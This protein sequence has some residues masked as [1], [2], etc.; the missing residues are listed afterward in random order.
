MARVYYGQEKMMLC[1]DD[2][3]IGAVKGRRPAFKAAKQADLTWRPF[4][5]SD[6]GTVSDLL[7]LVAGE[8]ACRH[9]C[10]QLECGN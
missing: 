4:D 9:S 2:E 10:R 8:R 5:D 1:W 3:W 6:A 7:G